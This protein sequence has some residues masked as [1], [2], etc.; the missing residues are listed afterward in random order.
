MPSSGADHS[1]VGHADGACSAR[2]RCSVGGRRLLF[3]WTGDL[4][5]LRSPA[6]NR[7]VEL[8]GP[9]RRPVT[10]HVDDEWLGLGAALPIPLYI[11]K[12][13]DSLAKRA[14]Q[15][16][17]LTDLRTTPVFE[18]YRKQPRPTTSCQVRAGVEH[19]F[20]TL[21]DHETSC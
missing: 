1:H 5:L 12:A 9:G 8:A 2:V 16:L 11:G 21:T 15:H 19:L 3:L 6:C 10:L 18:G 7:F 14:G 13:A 17:R 20:P 4:E